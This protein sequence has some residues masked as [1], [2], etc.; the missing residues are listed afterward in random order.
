LYCLW[1]TGALSCNV[2]WYLFSPSYIPVLD[3]S[4]TTTYTRG[5]GLGTSMRCC[6]DTQ[7]FASLQQPIEKPA[8]Y[9]LTLHTP[10][11]AMQ[12]MLRTE[13]VILSCMSLPLF[14]PLRG[15]RH[16]VSL[17]PTCR[18]C[19]V[20][21]V[22]ICNWSCGSKQSQHCTVMAGEKHDLLVSP[23]DVCQE[24]VSF[25]LASEKCA[26]NKSQ[27]HISTQ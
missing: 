18:G 23:Q 7:P 11:D 9:L 25:G 5:V 17:D 10:E 8:D 14:K 15:L 21:G 20:L 22:S 13:L 19:V 1:P 12:M 6:C 26:K 2:T 4:R 27:P 24:P 3:T 16:P